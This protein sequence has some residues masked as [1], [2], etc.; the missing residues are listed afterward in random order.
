[1][2]SMCSCKLIFAHLSTNNSNTN[3]KLY[4]LH[5]IKFLQKNDKNLI[6]R[7]EYNRMFIQ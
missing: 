6:F 1:M 5:A 4:S 7:L 2:H 3:Y